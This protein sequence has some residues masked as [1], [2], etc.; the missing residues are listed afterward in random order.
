MAKLSTLINNGSPDG[1]VNVVIMGDG[2]TQD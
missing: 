2:Y 1:R